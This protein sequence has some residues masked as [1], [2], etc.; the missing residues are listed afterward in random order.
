LRGN[1]DTRL[2]KLDRGE[3]DGIVLAASGLRRLGL[4]AR[5]R[6]PLDVAESLPAAGQGA[7]GIEIRAGRPELRAWLQPLV[8]VPTT[9]CVSA[10]RAVSRALAG[11]CQVPLAAHAVLE[12]DDTLYL[13]ALVAQPDGRR[14]LRE[15]ARGPLAE[16]QALGEQVA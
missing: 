15:E 13:R 9:A 11:S 7:L 5:I 12:G 2:A 1:L 10:E 4:E 3:Y 6:S 8:H 14:V 16:A